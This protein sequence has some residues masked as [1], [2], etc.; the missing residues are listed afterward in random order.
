MK[1]PSLERPNFTCPLLKALSFC[2]IWA[3]AIEN[4]LLGDSLNWSESS[5]PELGFTLRVLIRFNPVGIPTSDSDDEAPSFRLGSAISNWAASPS[6]RGETET[7]TE[8]VLMKKKKKYDLECAKGPTDL[9]F[10]KDHTTVVGNLVCPL[11]IK[12]KT[13][14][15]NGNIVIINTFWF[16]SDSLN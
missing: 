3:A 8:R 11:P 13:K 6:A 16:Q 4:P 15:L 7:E 9:N 5:S 1:I 2:F 10:Q 12:L 14:Q